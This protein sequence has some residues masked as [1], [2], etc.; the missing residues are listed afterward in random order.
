MKIQT[1]RQWMV[2]HEWMI[3]PMAQ[4]EWISGKGLL[5]WLAEVF[6]ALGTGL[7][8]ASLFFF[9]HSPLTAFW[10]LI[11]GWIMIAFFKLPLHLVYLGK[12]WRFWRAFPPFSTNWTRS[13]FSRG[14]VFTT[15]FLVFA[16][17]QMVLQGLMAYDVV[18]EGGPHWDGVYGA[19]WVFM[20]LAG[21]TCAMTGIYCGFA[22]SYCKSVPFWNTGLL[23]IIFLMMGIADG[24]ALLMG[25]GLVTGEGVV[26]PAESATR[27]VLIINALLILAYLVNANYQSVVAELAVKELIVGKLAWV[28]WLGIVILGIIVPFLVSVASYFTGEEASAGLLVFAIVCHTIGAFSLKYGVLK[29][30]IYRPLLPKSA[31]Y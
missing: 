27:I 19:N 24:L 26:A 9:K 2:T 25:V 4:T 21:L 16:I 11:F 30:G 8:I 18:T 12:P 15:V 7:Y 14:I 10:G 6:S 31:A 20:V 13:W 29:V 22:M 3:K 1:S 28:F 23:P 5:V 17:V